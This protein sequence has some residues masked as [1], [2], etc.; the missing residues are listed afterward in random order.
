MNLLNF[1][2]ERGLQLSRAGQNLVVKPADKLTDELRTLI[3]EHKSELLAVLPDRELDRLIGVI[4]AY[5]GFTTEQTNEAR[6]IAADDPDTALICY[7]SLAA[8]VRLK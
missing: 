3:R 2:S 7:R 5:H 6:E 1:L 8:K 4:A